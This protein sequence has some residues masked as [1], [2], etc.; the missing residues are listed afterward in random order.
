[1]KTLKR[2][3]CTPAG[4][5]SETSFSSGCTDLLRPALK[6]E[7]DEEIFDE[8]GFSIQNVYPAPVEW[9]AA[10]TL[11]GHYEYG[12][13]EKHTI[14]QQDPFP[15]RSTHLQEQ[16]QYL[17]LSALSPKR[18]VGRYDNPLSGAIS[19]RIDDNSQ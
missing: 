1:M 19:R 5:S 2:L 10:S 17:P 9:I 14:Q 16:Y 13:Q 11:E 8:H 7:E 3:A 4:D 6:S 12:S 18:C 15:D